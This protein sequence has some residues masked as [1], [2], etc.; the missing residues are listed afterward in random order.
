MQ[1]LLHHILYANSGESYSLVLQCMRKW[2]VY[3]F[4]L[5]NT[6]K[7][8]TMQLFKSRFSKISSVCV[9]FLINY[10]EIRKP[11]RNAFCV[12]FH[13]QLLLFP[14]PPF[15]AYHIL[16]LL[17]H[18]LWYINSSVPLAS[19]IG[20]YTCSCIYVHIPITETPSIFWAKGSYSERIAAIKYF[21][22]FLVCS[23][24]GLHTSP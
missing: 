13:S 2:F 24:V 18:I 6:K 10:Q 1:F 14:R 7:K 20:K 5:W 23:S 4:T 15:F 17:C 21:W 12:S 8:M 11:F 22:D 19:Q 16:I 9:W 3:I